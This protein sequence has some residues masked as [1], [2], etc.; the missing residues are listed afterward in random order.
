MVNVYKVTCVATDC[1]TVLTEVMKPTAV[2]I[3][4]DFSV[5]INLTISNNVLAG[6]DD[7]NVVIWLKSYSRSNGPYQV[8][9][10]E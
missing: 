3:L 6:L 4:Q 5:S 2:S 10:A 1:E 9:K 7:C 8:F